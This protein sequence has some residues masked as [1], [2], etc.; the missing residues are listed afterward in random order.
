DIGGSIRVPSH[1]CGLFGHKPSLNLVSAAGH[2]PGGNRD[3]PGF[4]TLLAVAGPI[5][6]SAAD[7]L[8]AIKILGGPIGYD[9]KA[10]RWQLPGPR[11]TSL[12]NFRVGYV[13]DD[14][15]APPVPEMKPLLEKTISALDRAGAQL[16][17]GWPSGFSIKAL[18]DTYTFLLL[19]F[20]FS[21]T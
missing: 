16:K 21:V 10:W 4:D 9:A 18:L 20:L 17:P 2:L 14:P 7:L 5:A 11:A 3:N 6:R 1:F 12:K 19:A 13:I 8:A 15:I